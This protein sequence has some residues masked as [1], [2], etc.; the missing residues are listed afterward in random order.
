MIHRLINMVWIRSCCLPN[1]DQLRLE[2]EKKKVSKTFSL[3]SGIFDQLFVREN[4]ITKFQK[5]K[6]KI[7]NKT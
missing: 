1:L 7:R 2:L 5:K 6:K 4:S 3:P